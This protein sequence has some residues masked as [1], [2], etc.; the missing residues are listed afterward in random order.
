MAITNNGSLKE[1]PFYMF[2]LSWEGPSLLLLLLLS[3]LS[4]LGVKSTDDVADPSASPPVA[5]FGLP[6]FLGRYLRIIPSL[7]KE[8]NRPVIFAG[9]LRAQIQPQIL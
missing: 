6:E 3:P 9:A 5:R 4:L 2:S 1:R 8:I 7:T